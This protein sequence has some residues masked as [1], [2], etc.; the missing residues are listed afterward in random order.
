MTTY[1]PL[2]ILAEDEEDLQ[3]I[4]ACLQDALI[5]LSGMEYDQEAKRFHLVANR[6]CWECAPEVI[7]GDSFYKR[8]PVGLAFHN[9]TEIKTKD[10]ALQNKHELVNLLTIQDQAENCIHLVFSGGTEIR[11]TV[12]KISCHLKDVDE[13][14]PTPHKPCHEV[15]E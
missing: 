7:E 10:L 5:P 13:P 15:G 11:L 12:D 2:R 14:Y 8:V 9:V 1:A 6:F 4:A 3:V